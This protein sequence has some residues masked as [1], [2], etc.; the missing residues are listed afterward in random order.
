LF[1]Q[2]IYFKPKIN[3]K[4]NYALRIKNLLSIDFFRL[5]ITRNKMQEPSPQIGAVGGSYKGTT[6]CRMPGNPGR[7]VR[8]HNRL[9]LKESGIAKNRQTG[10][11]GED[12]YDFSAENPL[13]CVAVTDGKRGFD[14][15][16]GL[17]AGGGRCARRWRSGY[18]RHGAE[19]CPVN[20]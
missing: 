19:T 17:C 5:L 15:G 8:D 16:A 12:E 1:G 18:Y 3:L 7:R 13:C 14:S 9:P 4:R 20:Q 10:F 11:F 2:I 6:Y